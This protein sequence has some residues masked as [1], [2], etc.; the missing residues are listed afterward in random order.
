MQT[1]PAAAS[2]PLHPDADFAAEVLAEL[3][4][5]P[6][7]RPWVA[8]LLW[9]LT[10]WFGGHRFYLDRP[11]TALLM[12]L[13]GGGFFFGW[14]VDAFHLGRMVREYNEDQARRRQEG[15]PP[16]SLAFMPPLSR[17]VLSRPPAWTEQWRMAGAARQRARLTADAVVLALTG[18]LLGVVADTTG[19]YEAVAAIV[20]LAGLSAAGASV[21]ALNDLPVAG[22]LV[23]WSHRLRLFYYY[24]RPGRPLALLF[25][26]VTAAITAPFRKRDRAEVKLYLQLG[27][28]FTLLFLLVDLGQAFAE[29]GLGALSPTSLFG[30]WV[31]EAVGTF[32]VIYA[33]ATPI[34]AVLTTHL[35]MRR[36]HFVP[37][38]LGALVVLAVV[39][40]ILA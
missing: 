7:K 10:G 15:Q 24:N 28:V 8:R 40:G 11:G 33:F 37:R 16:R 38:M 36:T 12:L 27:G 13:T 20:A 21:G 30:L 25:R 4:T 31:R 35:L 39:L 3:Y 6:P 22:E 2:Q 32:L 23:R 34:G 14:V 9:A 1:T 29:R 18:L 17:D 5:Y 26:P 19:I